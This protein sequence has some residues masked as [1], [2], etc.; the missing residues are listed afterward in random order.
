MTTARRIHPWLGLAALPRLSASQADAY[1]RARAVE[2]RRTLSGL[3]VSLAFLYLLYAAVDVLILGDVAL[4][5]LGLRFG[6]I[7]PLALMLFWYQAAPARPIRAKEIATLGV[8]IA[9]H[10]AWCVIL[11]ASDNARR[12]SHSTM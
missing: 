6:L 2:R 12:P 3:T 1:Q 9:G 5:S 11:V 7:L 4:L 10:L 8:A